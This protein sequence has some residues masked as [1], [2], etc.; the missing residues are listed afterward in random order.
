LD[1]KE[2][3][4]KNKFLALLFLGLIVFVP[5]IIFSVTFYLFVYSFA[6]I[7]AFF[8]YCAILY[9]H[10]YKGKKPKYPLVPPEGQTDIYFP[11]TDIPRPIYEDVRR[12]PG[13]FKPKKKRRKKK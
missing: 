5:L 13:F 3:K 2:L 6:Y 8:V 11:R 12:Y 7:F 4:R 9:K 10:V 1:G